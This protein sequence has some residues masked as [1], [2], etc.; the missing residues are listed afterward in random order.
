MREYEADG[1]ITL[2]GNNSTWA[3]G[4]AVP[5]KTPRTIWRVYC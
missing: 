3:F 5:V 4:G 2:A 1:T